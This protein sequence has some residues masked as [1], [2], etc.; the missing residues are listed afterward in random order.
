[1]R[2]KLNIKWTTPNGIAVWLMDKVMLKK[3]K[4]A[5]CYRL[6][7]G[8][9]SGNKDTLDFI[10]KKYDYNY[11]YEIIKYAHKIGLWTIGTFIIG[12]PYEKLESINDTINFA[13]STYLDF[14][15]FYIANPF[16]GTKMYDYFKKENLI[17]QDASSIVRGVDTK[18][19]KHKE[20]ESIQS[21]AFFKFLRSRTLRPWRILWR[22]RSFEDIT[23]TMKL[24][25]HFLKIIIS[26]KEMKREGTAALWKK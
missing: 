20:L 12:F 22:L 10:G 4:Q 5:G 25:Q 3:M 11:A 19:F 21:E 18:N 16:P 2:R 23:Y 17:P 7:F 9:E 15:I 6:T 13:T 8:L 26:S 24:F 1:M 14:A